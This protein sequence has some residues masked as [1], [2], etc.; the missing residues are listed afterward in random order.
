MSAGIHATEV[1]GTQML[2]ELVYELATRENLRTIEVLENIILVVLPCLN[3][4]RQ[5]MVIDWY[6]KCL[7]T[8]YKGSPPPWLYHKYCGHD[9][10]RDAFMLTQPESRYIARIIYG[11]FIPRS[12]THR[13]PPD[14]LHYG[15]V[16]RIPRDCCSA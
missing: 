12:S 11:E 16:L 15:Q 1:A 10:N 8:E 2:I 5:I 13:S 3:P 7:G 4:D 9:N 14:G 6:Y